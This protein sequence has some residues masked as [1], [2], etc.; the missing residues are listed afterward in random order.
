MSEHYTPDRRSVLRDLLV[1]VGASATS[2]LSLEALAASAAQPNTFFDPTTFQTLSRVADTLIPQTD[3]A[4]ALAVDV[5]TRPDALM[6]EWASSATQSE[7]REALV[8]LEETAL[9]QMDQQVHALSDEACY[10]FMLEYDT[11]ALQPAEPPPNA[12]K[13]SLFSSTPYVT[14]N[15][16]H[17]LKTLIVTL[18][19]VSERALT[20]ELIYQ[21][22]PGEWEPSIEIT[23]GMHAFASIGLI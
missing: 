13:Q 15:G 11:A 1:L 21:H 19:Y 10:Q 7:I 9:A 12:P 14:D 6:R 17:R 3:T 18:Y 2:G 16:Y 22:I 20:E 23:P 8:R 4:G 5:P